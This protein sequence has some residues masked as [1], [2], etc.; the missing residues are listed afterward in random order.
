MTWDT[1]DPEEVEKARLFF[2]KVTKQG[3]LA[4]AWEANKLRR[5]LE[6]RPEQ[7]KLCFIPLAEGG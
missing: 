6:F 7:G 2:N 3:W 1:K 5:T 4:M